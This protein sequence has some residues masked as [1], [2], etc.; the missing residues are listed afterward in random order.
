MQ[1]GCG[2]MQVRSDQASFEIQMWVQPTCVTTEAVL[3]HEEIDWLVPQGTAA[4][5]HRPHEDFLQ[6]RLKEARVHDVF[7]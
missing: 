3:P 2:D 1:Q 7:W 4:T 5:M 6:A